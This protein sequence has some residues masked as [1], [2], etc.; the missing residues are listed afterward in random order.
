MILITGI[1]GYLG[2]NIYNHFKNKKYKIYGTSRKKN[3]NSICLI[4]FEKPRIKL[5]LLKK[6]DIKVIIHQVSL[7]QQ[8]CLKF[9]E[10]AHNVSIN[11]TF[12]IIEIARKLGVKKIIYFSTAQVYGSNLIGYVNEK[13]KPIPINNYSMIHLKVEKILQRNSKFF[14]NGTFILRLSNIFG[15]PNRKELKYW[16]LVCNDLCYQAINNKKIFLKSSGKQYRD[17]FSIKSLFEILENVINTNLF[18]NK[19][20]TFNVGN[21]KSKSILSLAKIIQK[22]CNILFKYYPSININ[23]SYKEI[24]NK[25]TFGVEKLHNSKINYKSENFIQSIDDTLSYCAKMRK[26]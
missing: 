21:G 26:K 4:D 14:S 1:N 10:L 13:T 25:Y 16:K 8:D 3:K 6:L 18:R 20:Y 11:G 12:K 24:S 15:S 22:R 9:P 23:K 19:S 17:F 5:N 2:H 7:N